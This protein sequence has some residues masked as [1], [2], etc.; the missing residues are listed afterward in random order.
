MQL[1]SHCVSNC[2]CAGKASRYEEGSDASSSKDHVLHQ[3]V[4]CEWAWNE[5]LIHVCVCVCVSVCVR[6][7]VCVCVM[8]MD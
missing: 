8:V 7:C 5:C 1:F 4:Q 6:V 3:S 2:V